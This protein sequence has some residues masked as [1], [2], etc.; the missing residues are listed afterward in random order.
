MV[1]LGY[2]MRDTGSRIGE[3][4]DQCQDIVSPFEGNPGNKGQGR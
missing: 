2:I 1:P 3:G 4:G